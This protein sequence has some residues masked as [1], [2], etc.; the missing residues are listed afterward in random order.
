MPKCQLLRNTNLAVLQ[1]RPEEL[2]DGGLVRGQPG[3]F[4]VS[5]EGLGLLQLNQ[6]MC[7][8]QNAPRPEA[9]VELFR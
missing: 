9:F 3:R 2:V 4:H 7:P 6:R 1:V 5:L 8:E